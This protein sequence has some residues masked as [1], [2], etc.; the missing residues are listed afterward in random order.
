MFSRVIKLA[1]ITALFVWFTPT[2]ESFG[3]MFSTATST[4]SITSGGWGSSVNSSAGAISNQP[5]TLNWNGSIKRQA[6]FIA[7]INAGSLTLNAGH[8]TF[9]SAKSNG[10][11]TNP[12]TLTFDVCSGT[13]NQGAS[14]CSGTITTFASATGGTVDLN[15]TIAVGAR[16]IIRV[17]NQNDTNSNYKTTVNAQSLRSDIR[18]GTVS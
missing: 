15:Q 5:Y 14:T 7:L 10:D 18:L 2:T 1:L 3:R 4:V 9:V 8:L 13:W 17:T 6:L 16:V 11:T 12:P